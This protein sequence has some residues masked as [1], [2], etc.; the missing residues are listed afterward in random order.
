MSPRKSDSRERML[1]ST[2]TFLREYGANVTSIERV[3]AMTGVIDAAM[4]LE[5]KANYIR[6]AHTNGQTL[7]ATGTVIHSDRRTATAE[8]KG[9]G[10]T[11]QAPACSNC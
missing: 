7:T 5:L 11:R 4:Q 3:L 10:R 6:A 1:R 2:M 9:A 8:G